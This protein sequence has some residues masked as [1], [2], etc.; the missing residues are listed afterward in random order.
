MSDFYHG[1]TSAGEE[2]LWTASLDTQKKKKKH[3]VINGTLYKG[4]VTPSGKWHNNDGGSRT[5][6]SAVSGGVYEHSQKWNLQAHTCGIKNKKTNKQKMTKRK[7]KRRVS[8]QNTEKKKELNIS[9]NN[10]ICYKI[11]VRFVSERYNHTRRYRFIRISRSG[12]KLFKYTTGY[13][14][15]YWRP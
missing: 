9:Q 13:C 7:K 8:F 4:K 15:T 12:M 11:N 6:R 2:E 10:W 3:K 5:W 14:D 1:Y